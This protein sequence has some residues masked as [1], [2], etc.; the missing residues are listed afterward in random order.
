MDVELKKEIDTF[1]EDFQRKNE[2]EPVETL[3]NK[4][5]DELKRK[6]FTMDSADQAEADEYVQQCYLD[7]VENKWFR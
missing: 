6:V 2:S 1:F 5:S 7:V 3:A 4:L